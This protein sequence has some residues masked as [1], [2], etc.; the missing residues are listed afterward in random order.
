M[1]S[2][3]HCLA[4]AIVIRTSLVREAAET[5]APLSINKEAAGERTIGSLTT[6]P[7]P[8]ILTLIENSTNLGPTQ[9][10]LPHTSVYRYQLR[11]TKVPTE[12]LRPWTVTGKE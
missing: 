10:P 3:R 1:G 8:L 7:T 2:E 6:E 5:V 4:P 12:V 9:I 11:S